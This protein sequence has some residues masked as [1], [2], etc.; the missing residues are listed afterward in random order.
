[1]NEV[2]ISANEAY[3]QFYELT[4]RKFIKNVS[5]FEGNMHGVYYQ[6]QA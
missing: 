5:P 3:T 2:F 6:N 1:M 4:S